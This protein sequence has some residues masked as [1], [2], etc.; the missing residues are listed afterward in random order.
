MTEQQKVDAAWQAA[1]NAVDAGK[2]DRAAWDKLFAMAMALDG[3]A[4]LHELEAVG[5]FGILQGVV[6]PDELEELLPDDE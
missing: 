5:E 3:E 2:F 6:T 4:Q 1:N